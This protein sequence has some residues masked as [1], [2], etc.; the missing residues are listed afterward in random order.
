MLSDKIQENTTAA[1]KGRDE[2][3]LSTLR[4]LQSD[5]KNKEIE[6]KENLTDDEIVQVIRKQ[7]KELVEAA[8]MFKK[9]NRVDLVSQNEKQIEILKKYLPL[10]ISDDELKS[11]IEKIM[12]ESRDVYEKNPKAIIGIVM[13][14]LKSKADPKRIMQTLQNI[15][16]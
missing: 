2:V 13:S 7:V 3:T 14:A 12:T 6:K 4:F 1:L 9:G 10:E 16:G 5:I 15:Q 11:E 8:E